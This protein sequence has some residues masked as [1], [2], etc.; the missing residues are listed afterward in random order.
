MSIPF[1]SQNSQCERNTRESISLLSNSHFPIVSTNSIAVYDHKQNFDRNTHVL[2]NVGQKIFSR[3][4]L[5][6]NSGASQWISIHGFKVPEH[7]NT[8]K[9][10]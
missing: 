6:G 5:V 8:Y 4:S 10:F 7:L 3:R 2:K 1:Q 9:E